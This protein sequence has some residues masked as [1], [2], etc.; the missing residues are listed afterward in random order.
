MKLTKLKLGVAAMSSLALAGT[1]TLGMSSVA[2]AAPKHFSNP[3]VTDTGTSS[4]LQFTGGTIDSVP[5]TV[6]CTSFVA[7]GVVP[8]KGL[9][10]TLSAPP[11]ISGCTDSLGG[12][13][14]VTTKGTGWKLVANSSGSTLTLD[15][16]SKSATFT[17]SAL[18]TCTVTAGPAK[19]A[20]S[21]NNLNAETISSGGPV[22][23][24]GSGCSTGGSTVVNASVSFNQ[25]ESVV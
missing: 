8:S 20:G 18:S 16:P 23:T 9:S 25:N 10:I 1:L 24:K 19:V 5:V 14:T 15:Q 3:G 4:N 17:S 12:T 13:D 6:N 7:S 11:T 2:G 21:Y 22:K